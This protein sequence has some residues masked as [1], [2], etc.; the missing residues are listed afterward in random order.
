ML[1][2]AE[3]VAGTIGG[4]KLEF[5][6]IAKARGMLATGILV[7]RREV[8]L[9]PAIGQCCGGRVMLAFERLSL[10]DIGSLASAERDAANAR[11]HVVIYGAGH[12][13]RALA[14][15]L[16]PLPLQVTIADGR[17]TEIALVDVENIAVVADGALVRIAEKAPD[18]TAHVVMTHSHAL[19]C[20]IG[21]TVLE[22]NR[23][24]YLGI[25][26]SRTKKAMF[27]RAFREAGISEEL[28][29]RV[30]CP[31]GGS[32]VRDKRPEVIAALA[33]AE[34]TT[35]LLG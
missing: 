9:G 2:S 3:S 13:G 6:A 8:A 33:A 17:A 29:R 1:V 22:R 28:I 19:D 10:A 12:V 32:R 18:Y 24:R 15:A 34:I 31:I 21:A 25:I 35:A 7:A 23:F 27:R 5:D 20:L 26:G 11:P 14:R 30:V 4:G 16:G